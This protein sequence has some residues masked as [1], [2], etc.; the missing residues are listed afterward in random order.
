MR[1]TPVAKAVLAE[2]TSL[3]QT[4]NFLVLLCAAAAAG[5][6]SQWNLQTSASDLTDQ[7]SAVG[8]SPVPANLS[9]VRF[10]CGLSQLQEPDA[11]LKDK[12]Q[13]RSGTQCFV[14]NNFDEATVHAVCCCDRETTPITEMIGDHWRCWATKTHVP[15]YGCDIKCCSRHSGKSAVAC[16]NNDPICCEE[17]TAC[18][19]ALDGQACCATPA[20]TTCCTEVGATCW[21]RPDGCLV[22]DPFGAGQQCCL[23]G[24]IDDYCVPDADCKSSITVFGLATGAFFLATLIVYSWLM[25]ELSKEEFSQCRPA[26]LLV[27]KVA[28][29]SL[30]FVVAYWLLPLRLLGNPVRK[31]PQLFGILLTALLIGVVLGRGP[32]SNTAFHSHKATVWIYI[33]C[34]AQT[35]F[36]IPQFL[37]VD[38]HGWGDGVSVYWLAYKVLEQTNIGS[39][40]VWVNGCLTDCMG[41]ATGLQTFRWLVRRSVERLALNLRRW[42]HLLTADSSSNGD[43]QTESGESRREQVQIYRHNSRLFPRFEPTVSLY[44]ACVPGRTVPGSE[45]QGDLMTRMVIELMNT[46]PHASPRDIYGPLHRK[47]W[48]ARRMEGGP[49]HPLLITTESLN[50]VDN[51]EHRA[52][53]ST[54]ESLTSEGS[55]I[56]PAAAEDEERP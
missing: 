34:H 3:Y 44:F 39:L 49:L 56:A 54:S 10:S 38:A 4:L 19:K 41:E 55:T 43:T 45:E 23:R 31:E 33:S 47:L 36:G 14:K 21:H 22:A 53:C 26:F 5:G 46:S 15:P 12:N 9:E 13:C 7:V 40:H 35:Y 24:N 1:S 30:I 29:L 18:G 37:P 42:Y 32:R 28:A 27:L 8:V 51:V 17:G 6:L 25:G 50:A 48:A 11:C 16:F 2:M 20:N 52:R